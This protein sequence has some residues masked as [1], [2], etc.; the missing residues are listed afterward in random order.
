MAHNDEYEKIR[1]V[2]REALK[3]R[4][5]KLKQQGKCV[6]CGKKKATKGKTLC[7]TCRKKRSENERKRLLRLKSAG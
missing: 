5:A 2:N 4:R 7:L 1:A 3:K 6:D